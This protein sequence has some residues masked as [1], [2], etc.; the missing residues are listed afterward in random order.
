MTFFFESTKLLVILFAII[1]C[2]QSLPVWIDK[3]SQA[4]DI[5]AFVILVK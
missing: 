4:Y 3:E 5:I 1:F 2:F